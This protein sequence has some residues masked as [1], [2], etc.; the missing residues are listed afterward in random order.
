MK[1][2]MRY[3]RFNTVQI[4]IS[5]CC[6]VCQN[7]FTVKNIQALIFHRAHIEMTHRN[8]LKQ[9]KIIFKAINVLVP[10]HR[11]F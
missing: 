4:I 6:R 3:D 8:N 1:I 7:K 5:G 11:T 9:V 10:P 2:F